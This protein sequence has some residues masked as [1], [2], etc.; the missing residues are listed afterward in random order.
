MKNTIQINSINKAIHYTYYYIS[1]KLHVLNETKNDQINFYRNCN[2]SYS[3]KII[4]YNNK[5]LTLVISVSIVI[6]LVT[7]V[8]V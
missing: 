3:N 4:N 5:Y 2:C 7:R 8:S 1:Q 6:E